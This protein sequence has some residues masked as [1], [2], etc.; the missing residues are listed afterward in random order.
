MTDSSNAEPRR[1]KSLQ[2]G[3]EII[4][5]VQELDGASLQEIESHVDLSRGTIHTYLSTLVD[6]RL[7]VRNDNVYQL[8]YR[9]ITMGEYVR[10]TTDIY[11]AGQQE[12]DKLAE[13]S[14]E[15][16]HLVIED[17]GR[18]VAI[19]ERRGQQAVGT[20]YHHK[21]RETPQYLHDSASGKAMLAH[22]PEGRI[23]N[24]IDRQGL[25]RQTKNTIVDRDQLWDELEEVKKCGYAINDEEEIRG[26]RAVGAPIIDS[27]ESV[28][29]AVS[30]TAPT[31]RLK[32][33]RFE[34][35]IPE[36]VMETANLIEVNL[37]TMT[38][39]RTV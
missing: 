29:G 17:E 21:M 10:N 26:L 19:Y 36:L 25:E 24:I 2:R 5:V 16:V 39:D 14:G 15:Y 13:S 33:D 32:G 12:V 38:F 6:C 30:L 1:I 22:L 31:S 37:E 28:V 23:E 3:C 18:E 34:S 20:D 35:E 27:D 9:F 4:E 7:L 11:T 8:G